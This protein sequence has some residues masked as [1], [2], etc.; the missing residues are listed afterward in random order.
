MTA[1]HLALLITAIVTAVSSLVAIRKSSQKAD[2][3]YVRDVI[4]TQGEENDRM[5]ADLAELR[6]ENAKLRDLCNSL[7]SQL[8]Q[9]NRELCDVRAENAGL[10][11]R[12][13]EL[14]QE[15]VSLREELEKYRPR[16]PKAGGA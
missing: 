3:D 11:V 12:M 1:E 4:K 6:Q 2:L 7:Q 8:S 5:K 10:K 9:T 16:K 14:E 13:G 15:N